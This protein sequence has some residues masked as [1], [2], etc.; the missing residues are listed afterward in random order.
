MRAIG[1]AGYI[2]SLS[3]FYILAGMIGCKKLIGIDKKH[4]NAEEDFI[5]E[6]EKVKSGLAAKKFLCKTKDGYA[7]DRNIKFLINACCEPSAFVRFIECAK[8][9]KRCRYY[10]FHRDVVIELDQDRL[11]EDT[12]ILTPMESVGKAFCNMEEFFHIERMMTEKSENMI[13]SN[14][15]S[16][17][18]DILKQMMNHKT[19][20]Y[21]NNAHIIFP[22][23]GWDSSLMQDLLYAINESDESYS[24][25]VAKL[26]E[27]KTFHSSDIY[28]GKRYFWKVT[29]SQGQ[30]GRD[31]ISFGAREGI[32]TE[33]QRFIDKIKSIVC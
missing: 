12:Y 7:I 13:F 29:G 32:S 23:T 28:A 27:E 14:S 6:I 21:E 33:A 18:H 3:E 25:L 1:E 31:M 30:Q 17:D 24:M 4:P 10:Y 11:L 22:D 15:Y 20:R 26:D 8:G 19:A 9:S 5:G 16:L 2:L